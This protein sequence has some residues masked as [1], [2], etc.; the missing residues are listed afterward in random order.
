MTERFIDWD[1]SCCLATTQHILLRRRRAIQI[2]CYCWRCG[3]GAGLAGAG[4]AGAGVR[5][6]STVTLTLRSGARATLLYRPGAPNMKYAP[7]RT[8]TTNAPTMKY[9]PPP[10]LG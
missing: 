8:A 2:R 9:R 4:L 5:G 7:T 3:G 10:L 1:R 6:C